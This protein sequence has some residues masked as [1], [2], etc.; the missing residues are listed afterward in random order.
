MSKTQN[1]FVIF[2]NPV[3]HSKSPQMQN[4]GLKYI[5]FNGIYEKH[6]L[7]NGNDI[8]FQI[9]FN[10]SDE[11][12]SIQISE[13][14]NILLTFTFLNFIINVEKDFFNTIS[15]HSNII[16]LLVC[17]LIIYLIINQ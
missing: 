4:A 17:F 11:K 14:F 5:G 2:G 8:S 13:K 3:A 1:K 7:E 9:R 15:G 6:H 12:M 16:Q 10:Y